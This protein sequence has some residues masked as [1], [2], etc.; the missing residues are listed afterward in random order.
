[1]LVERYFTKDKKEGQCV[2]NMF[3]WKKVD[4]AIRNQQTGETVFEQ[5]DCEFPAH[6]SQTACEIIA[7]KYFYRGLPET[8]YK[9]VVHR[10]AKFWKDALIDEGVIDEK[11]GVIFYDEVVY[12]LIDQMW[13]PNSPQWFNSGLKYYDLEADGDGLYYWD[14]E[15]EKAV[16]VK[17][18]YERTQAS[19]CFILDIKDKLLGP[20]SITDH[21]VNE[22]K[23]FKG[24]S[25][26]GTNFSPLRAEG[27]HLASGGT[28][29]G[30]MSYLEGL[31]KNAGT[32]KSGGTTRR[33][34]KMVIVDIDHPEIEDFIEWK[35]KE[36]R[37]A[38]VLGAAGYDM[39]IGG[40]AY[41][42]VSGQNSN[43]SIRIPNSFM[44]KLDDPDATITLTGRVDDCVNR[45]VKV[46]DLWDKIAR[47]AWECGDPAIQFSDTINEWNTC[48]ASGTINASNPC[49]EFMFLD[50]TA[51]NLASINVLKL[52]ENNLDYLVELVQLVLEASIHWG[53]FPTPEIA[54]NSY[55]F[56]PTGL[57][58]TNLAAFLLRLGLP[59]NSGE[60]RFITQ[61]MVKKINRTSWLTS[62]AIAL[63]VGAF[64]EYEKNEWEMK[65]I[66]GLQIGI[67][68]FPLYRNAQVTCIAPTGT[69][70]L[71]M[72]CISTGIEP[73]Y[74]HTTYKQLADGSVLEIVNPL[75]DESL[76]DD[77]L[78]TALEIS[79]EAHIEMMAVIQ[80]YISGA[81]SKTVNLPNDATV[82]DVKK[83][84]Y[85]AWEI[86]LKSIAIY[87]DGSKGTQV[88]ENE[89]SEKTIEVDREI[90]REKP[91]GIRD[92]VTHAAK[93]GGVELYVT[94]GYYSD[95][96]MAE[97]FVSTDK[98]GTII[99]GLL[100]SLSKT[101]SHLLQY[102][103]KP[104]DIA[105]MLQ[106]QKYEP[107]GIVTR[108]PYIK[109]ADS[110]SDFIARVIDFE[111]ENY[112]RCQV[113]PNILKEHSD[114]L[115]SEVLH[116]TSNEIEKVYGECCSVCGSDNLIKSGTCKT[117]LNCGS[118]TGCG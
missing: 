118:T 21:Y 103:I 93:I 72:D 18:R 48:K 37:K 115:K 77:V 42:T 80:P 49:S 64:E 96:R 10:M 15:K 50:N 14:P 24:G 54:E 110:I 65:D 16:E 38:K 52:D 90:V 102:G 92:S 45:E 95:G 91:D 2:Y 11:E 9:Q 17:N 13:A 68:P 76:P 58:I 62:Y 106:G 86:G 73:I 59:Y 35:V 60:A 117:C 22:T 83:I 67:K 78:A 1:M 27:E 111:C 55:K 6:F 79:P 51:C 74:S 43:N 82:E 69:I 53:Q 89:K 20:G 44:R 33:A 75:Y 29:S 7:S 34:A 107:S 3:K 5:K 26:C 39:S 31:D 87:R 99:K 112:S 36:E 25:G 19:A 46:S 101:I 113:K 98:E 4:V 108:H 63:K 41:S 61:Q 85:L 81:I 116:E 105:K 8:S 23:L 94:V 104:Q 40:E 109:M 57:G 30:L 56:R 114:N 32:I 28:S 12:T 71:A 100:A 70:S 47:A 97:I 84:F 88:L 66:V